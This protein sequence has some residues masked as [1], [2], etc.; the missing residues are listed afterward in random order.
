[1]A[2]EDKQG[3]SRLEQ[4]VEEISE[5]ERA[6]EL[7]KEHKRMKKKKRKENKCKF[8]NEMAE[9]KEPVT[10]GHVAESPGKE[11]SYKNEIEKEHCVSESGIASK[12]ERPG[13]GDIETKVNGFH[14]CADTAG[15]DKES[16]ECTASSKSI[17]C[18]GKSL[19]KGIVNGENSLTDS[20]AEESCD[21]GDDGKEMPQR[22]NG[23]IN[24]SEEKPRKLY[25][26][27]VKGLAANV[28]V[29]LP[30]CRMC[31]QQFLPS[32][33]Y[34]GVGLS[35]R[36][37]DAGFY[38]EICPKCAAM[39]TEGG[40]RRNRKKVNKSKEVSTPL[41]L[42]QEVIIDVYEEHMVISF[43][44][45]IRHFDAILKRLDSELQSTMRCYT[46]PPSHT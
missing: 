24:A 22:K 6:K 5:A 38:S 15:Q 45:K 41:L 18:E 14:V 12:E 16:V 21:C 29:S 1:M 27:E 26:K 28:Y 20:F 32:D 33:K 25:R 39:N 7:K 40:N 42:L 44:S 23:F 36:G 30:L 31:G 19:G 3:I 2:V 10:N 43:I 34:D 13:N 37:K 8:A 9:K 35:D 46:P 17:T 11:N 4:V